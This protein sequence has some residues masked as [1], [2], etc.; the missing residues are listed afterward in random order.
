MNTI[1]ELG[2]RGLM[3]KLIYCKINKGVLLFL[4]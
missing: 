2:F 1:D 3:T 4:G